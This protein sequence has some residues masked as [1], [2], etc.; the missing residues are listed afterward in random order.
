[1]E[2]QEAIETHAAEGYLLGDLT[3]AD[4]EAFE[5]HFA[6][7][8]TCFADVRDGATVMSA[9]RVDAREKKPAWG[10]LRNLIPLAAAASF[11]VFVPTIVYQRI[12]LAEARQPHIVPIVSVSDNRA[13]R[14]TLHGRG[15]FT[16][17]FP[18]PPTQPP[19]YKCAIV[20]A[21]GR[22]IRDV[23]EIV[24]A[25]QAK[26]AVP[27][28]I[29]AGLLDAGNYSLVVTTTGGVPVV[30]IEFRVE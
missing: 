29:P 5:E 19:P 6:D 12:Q 13:A 2:H 1:V 15:P 10:G 25:V 9:V 20:D 21:R 14:E 27:L 8:D 28:D 7:C 26:E 18:I 16:L 11:A 22:K 24:T 17:E 30:Q 3:A 4:H 23:P